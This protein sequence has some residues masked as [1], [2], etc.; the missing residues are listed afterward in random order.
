MSRCGTTSVP[1]AA[2]A[3]AIVMDNDLEGSDI[4]TMTLWPV[5]MYFRPVNGRK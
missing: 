4:M 3:V 1:N 2:V 5:S